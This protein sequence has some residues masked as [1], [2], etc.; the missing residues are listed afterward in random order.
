MRG[1][2]AEMMAR[3]LVQW[4]ARLQGDQLLVLRSK[5]GATGS[6][7]GIPVTEATESGVAY[8]DS[9]GP[10][11][12]PIS[13]GGLVPDGV[14]QIVVLADGEEHVG[15]VTDNVFA[16][17]VPRPAMHGA[18]ILWRDASGRTIREASR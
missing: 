2:A 5:G 13:F 17:E 15:E 9:A 11:D 4:R 18:T 12:G 7:R 8:V 14:A 6:G 10:T 3:H 1:A 16:V